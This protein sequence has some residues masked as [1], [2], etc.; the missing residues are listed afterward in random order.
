MRKQ[1]PRRFFAAVAI[2]VATLLLLVDAGASMAATRYLRPNG[3][4]SS[5]KPWVV[6][7]AGTAWEALADNVAETQ[8][9]T[10]AGYL[11]SDESTGYT[12]VGLQTMPLGGAG[13]VQA[14]AWVY[15][16][17]ANQVTIEVLKSDGGGRLAKGYSTG[18][19]WNSVLIETPFTQTELD[20]AVLKL[21]PTPAATQQIY[22]AFLKITY[23]PSPPKAYW[24]S[25]MDGDVYGGTGDA[26]W[27]SATWNT[28]QADSG[29][30]ASIVHF[31][32]PAPWQQSFSAQPLELTKARGAIPLM[33]M[34][35]K[36]A[37]LEEIANGTK[38]SYLNA[39]A[40]AVRS[41]G[42]PFFFR[43]D[44][45]MNG[46]W[47]TWGQEAAADPALFK[48]AWRHFRDVADAQGATNITW[49]WCPN[50]RFTGSTGLTS[51]YPGDAY[52][53]WTCIDGYNRGTNPINPTG[54]TKFASV[55][56]PTYNSLSTLAP[57]KPVMIGET[58]STEIGGSKAQ[59][60]SDALSTQLPN[61][62]PNVKAVVWF[63]WNHPSALEGSR[64]DWQIES[65]SSAQTAFAN[66]ISSPYYAG[67]TFG[68]LPSWTRVQPLP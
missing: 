27:S 19:G 7:G 50:T 61:R 40:K 62:F 1:S 57:S 49:V 58:A 68:N 6:A 21:R 33:D 26:P 59:W 2:S 9:P 23:T 48:S 20:N 60:I 52:V 11:A 5:S 37:T 66:A 3:D 17:N 16:G 56:A 31:G 13:G 30:A 38:D 43:W 41:Y 54:W 64:W 25:W 28:F 35:S 53:D 39:W 34:G 14:T 8:A 18:P 44:W 12:S 46:T 42:K 15:T 4:L 36:G 45:E 65:S 10:G 63:N 51:L 24:G 32:Q 67:N 29:R 55:I 22:A 47:Y